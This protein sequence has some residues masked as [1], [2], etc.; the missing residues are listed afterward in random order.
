MVASFRWNK[1]FQATDG[2]GWWAGYGATALIDPVASGYVAASA[3]GGNLATTDSSIPT[4]AL[5]ASG[6]VNLGLLADFSFPTLHEMV[7]VA[8]AVTTSFYGT[9]PDFSYFTGCSN[10]GRQG[11]ALAQKY[12]NDFNGIMANAPG[13]YWPDIFLHLNWAHFLMNPLHFYPSACE[14]SAFRNARIKACDAMDGVTDGIISA[15]FHCSFDPYS[16]VAQLP[17][18]ATRR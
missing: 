18:A 10:G 17:N 11:Y 16:I 8:K 14:Y 13:L 2:G 5:T 12:P 15:P 4:N 1:R 9:P 7:V 6:D 3:D